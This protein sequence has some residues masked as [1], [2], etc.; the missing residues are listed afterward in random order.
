MRARFVLTLISLVIVTRAAGL[1]TIGRVPNS[2]FCGA[3]GNFVLQVTKSEANATGGDSAESLAED[4]LKRFSD[5]QP[6]VK[7]E[8]VSS[9][10]IDLYEMCLSQLPLQGT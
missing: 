8:P 10:S 4:L 2:L 5:T 9:K 6:E 7:K 1:S 3:N